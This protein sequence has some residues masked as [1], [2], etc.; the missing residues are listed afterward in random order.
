MVAHDTVDTAARYWQALEGI[1]DPEIPVVNIVEMGMILGLQQTDDAVTVHFRPTF[2]GC[3][4]L[5]LIRQEIVRALEAAGAQTVTVV[6]SRA[7][8]STDAMSE[9]AKAK[10]AAYGIAPPQPATPACP[11]CASRQVVLKNP[12]GATLCKMLYQCQSC[13][14]P[15]EAFKCVR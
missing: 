9:T 5:A 10:L 8:W 11:R 2:S 4:A 13:G 6:D 3:P 12:F 15:F 7:P 1:N 14:E